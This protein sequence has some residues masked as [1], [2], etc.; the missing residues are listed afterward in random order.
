MTPDRAVST[1]QLLAE[2]A[3]LV[4]RRRPGARITDLQRAPSAYGSSWWLED[5][6]LGLADGSSLSL[7]FKD[8]GREVPGSGARNAKP[9]RV[10]DPGREP[11]VYRTLLRRARLGAPDCW[12]IVSVPGTERHWLF[13]ERVHGVPLSE[14]GDRELWCAAARWIGRF[15]ACVMPPRGRAHPLLRHDRA[16]HELWLARALAAAQARARAPEPERSRG[17][18]SLA[19][20]QALAPLHRA[21]IE[22]ALALGTALIHGE[23]YP[24]NIMIGAAPCGRP[25][26]RP[27]DWEMAAVGP[28]LLDLAALVSGELVPEYR[29]AIVLAY[30]D[31]VLA[32]GASCPSLDVFLRGLAACRLLLAVQWQGWGLGWQAPA[33]HRTDWL[34]EATACARE[35]A[36]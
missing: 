15:H 20:L 6:T 17:L 18:E 8:L 31:A 32:T 9:A 35:L 30:R 13:L 1:E 3:P 27:V 5:L 16:Y 33:E 28:P 22:E 7:V 29:A 19:R 2:L 4:R 12:G 11:W 21:A 24:S 14:T 34:E 10:L 36:S 26:V 23:F 25:L